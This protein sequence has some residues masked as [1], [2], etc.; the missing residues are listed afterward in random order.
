MK[1]FAAG[2]GGRWPGLILLF[3]K[4]LY[5]LLLGLDCFW[6]VSQ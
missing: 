3:I 5:R 2:K 6:R 1:T 4:N